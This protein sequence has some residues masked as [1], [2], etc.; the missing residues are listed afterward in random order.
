[1]FFPP[2]APINPIYPPTLLR[3]AERFGAANARAFDDRGWPYFTGDAY[4]LF[5]PGYGDS[6]PSLLGAIGMTYEPAGGGVAGLAIR[7]PDGDT[8]TLRDRV[9]HHR[10]AGLTTLQTAA[11]EKTA[12]LLEFAASQREIGRDEQDVL[13]V[14]G[15]DTLRLTALVEHLRSQGVVV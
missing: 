10:V 7:R 12:L 11:T 13:L 3:W 14:P 4:D 1:F 9:D 8:L 6:W 5:Y 15:T 2:A